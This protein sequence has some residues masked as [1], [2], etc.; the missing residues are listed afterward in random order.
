[1]TEIFPKPK[2]VLKHPLKFKNDQNTP[3]TSKLT[4]ISSKPENDQNTPKTYKMTK[5]PSKS[6]K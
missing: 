4:E 1:M 3:E 6:I 5:I 2:N